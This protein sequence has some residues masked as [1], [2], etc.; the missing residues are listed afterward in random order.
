MLSNILV[1]GWYLN[2]NVGD[3]LFMDAFRKIFPEL[4]FTFTNQITS[5]QLQKNDAIFIGGGS[6]LESPV[7][8]KGDILGK[9]K[10]KL[11]FYIGVGSETNIHPTQLELMKLA[12]LI[13]IR[14]QVNLAKILLIN[15]NT[16]VIPDI[17]SSLK[18]DL[19]I[20]NKKPKSVLI[21]P[22]ITVVP[23]QQDAHWKHAAWDYFKSEFSQFLNILIEEKYSINF[24]PM[25]DNKTSS[26]S[27]AAIE[28]IN[29]MS[30]RQANYLL[31]PQRDIKSISELMSSYELIIT[32]RFHG[33]I[34]SE[35][36]QTPYISIYHHDKLKSSQKESKNF[37]S[38]F[39]LNKDLLLDNLKSSF[40]SNLPIERDIFEQLN[41]LVLDILYSE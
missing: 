4:K 18:D 31:S 34:L 11:I 22:N 28:L 9:I 40:N 10:Q 29:R 19:I 7:K 6:F 30:R 36:I 21:L 20:N 8:I 23:T 2:G 39:S 15:S 27:W 25:C 37:L 32:Q 33:I 13:A 38:Y 17:V 16:I 26:D 24:F 1:Y 3:D 14:S 35:M 12:K 5:E 41:K